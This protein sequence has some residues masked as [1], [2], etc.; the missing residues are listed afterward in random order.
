MVHDN[1]H[2]GFWGGFKE[3]LLKTSDLSSLNIAEV[4]AHGALACL[5]CRQYLAALA[6]EGEAMCIDAAISVNTRL[7]TLL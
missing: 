2:G 3:H 5:W 4:V 1:G 6:R 7:K